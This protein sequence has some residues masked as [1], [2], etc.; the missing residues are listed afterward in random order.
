MLG[1][2]GVERLGDTEIE[3][4]HERRPVGPRRDEE[5]RRLQVAVHDPRGVRV[6]DRLHGL[7]QVLDR[8]FEREPSALLEHLVEIQP[9]QILHDE[10]GQPVVEPARV[11]DAHDMLA[12]Q[13]RHRARLSQETADRQPVL[14]GVAPEKL[15]GDRL[16]EVRVVRGDDHAH[17]ADADDALDDELAAHD[18]TG[19]GD[20]RG[21]SGRV[22]PSGRVLPHEAHHI[23]S[24]VDPQPPLVSTL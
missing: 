23:E 17:P 18:L 8:L 20:P 2:G 22:T 3:H 7:E 5:V 9:A 14:R 12:L 15:D 19:L 4:L 24:A 11:H 10:V 6:G 21:R 16:F 13:V 1:S